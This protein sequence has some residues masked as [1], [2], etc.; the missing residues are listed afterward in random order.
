MSQIFPATSSDQ[1]E[2]VRDLFREYQAE[3]EVSHC[4]RGMDEEIAGLPGAYAPPQGRLLLATVLGQPAGCVGLRPFLLEGVCEMK[5]LFVRPTFRGGKVGRL[6]V[7]QVLQD[8]KALGYRSIRLD[9]YPVT[10]QAAIAMYRRFGFR[11]ISSAPLAPV[12]G[13]LY[14][15]CGLVW[16]K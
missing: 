11:E 10:M 3:L 15:E 1:I 8:A 14:M 12:E 9:T 13:L 4:L 6:L 2:Q 16:Q 5:R 7:E